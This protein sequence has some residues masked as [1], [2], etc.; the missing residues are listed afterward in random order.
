LPGV[1][2]PTHVP[3][4]D[5][6][7]NE[8]APA[9]R[10][11]ALDWPPAAQW[12]LALLLTL[13]FLLLGWHLYAGSRWAAR[14]T[15][16]G[17]A[18][19]RLD[20]NRA[21][22]PELRQLPGVGETLARHIVDERQ[23][24]GG[25]R[26]VDDLRRVRGI[27]PVTLEPLRNLVEVGPYPSRGEGPPLPPRVVRGARPEEPGPS[28]GPAPA[29]GKKVLPDETLDVNTASVT[30]LQRLPGIVPK[31][32]EGIVAARQLKPFTSADDLRRV[33]GIGPKILERLRPHVRV[34]P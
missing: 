5:V 34:G 23:R 28:P 27:G 17:P 12:T 2:A 10:T 21:T 15:E 32:A 29:P 9:Q 18:D 20:I 22:E 14:P 25:F 16:L 19:L 3:P 4:P 24:Q 13:A 7:G 6:S 8:P 31:L 30:D 1:P 26:S 11:E 33:R